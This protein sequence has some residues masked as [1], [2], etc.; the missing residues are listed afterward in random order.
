MADDFSVINSNIDVVNKNILSLRRTVEDVGKLAASTSRQ[1]EQVNYKV[2]K[3]DYALAKTKKEV[4][5]LTQA[6]AQF[7]REQRM[8]NALQQ[9]LTEIVRVR[10][11][12]ED[13]FGTNKLVRDNM[14]GILQASD[15][16]LITES[17]ISRCTEEL[18]I[19]APKYWLAPCLIALAA[20]ISDN[21]ALAKRAIAEACKRDREKT[22]LLFALI[23]RRVNAGR[24][25]NGKPVTNSTFEWLNEYF[26]MQN[27]HF[28]FKLPKRNRNDSKTSPQSIRI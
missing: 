2:E 20:W 16:A 27:P 19:S 22:C 18:M 4:E 13:K 17:T 12:L 15:L 14:L 9:A 8:S 5:I 11:E 3:L 10:Q 7:V 23:T 28:P 1:V 26:K 21:E 6:F 25:A 24:M